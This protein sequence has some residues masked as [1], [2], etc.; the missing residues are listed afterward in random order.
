MIDL[1]EERVERDSALCELLNEDV[2]SFVDLNLGI[3]L[4]LLSHLLVVHTIFT[5]L[6]LDLV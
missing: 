2:G 3:N 5:C 6:D 1:E 4:C